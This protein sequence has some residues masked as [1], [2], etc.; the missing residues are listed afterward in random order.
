MKVFDAFHI[1]AT[2]G[3]GSIVIPISTGIACAKTFSKKV[4]HALVIKCQNFF[5]KR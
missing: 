4:I 5:K 3:L 1:I 2:T